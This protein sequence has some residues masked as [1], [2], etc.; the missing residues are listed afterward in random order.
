[1]NRQRK[2]RLENPASVLGG[3]NC[4]AFDSSLLHDL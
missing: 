4:I 3:Q 2:K 1:M